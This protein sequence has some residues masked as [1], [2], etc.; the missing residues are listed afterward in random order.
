MRGKWTATNSDVGDFELLVRSVDN[1][2]V[3]IE[4][5]DCDVESEMLRIWMSPSGEKKRMI[6]EM[7]ERALNC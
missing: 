1:V 3:A 4:R 2:D 7:R 5:L 6:A